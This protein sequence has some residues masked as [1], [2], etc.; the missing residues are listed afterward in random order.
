MTKVLVI[1]SFTDSMLEF[2]GAVMTPW[3]LHTL[4]S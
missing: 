3:F 4:R 2:R 1:A